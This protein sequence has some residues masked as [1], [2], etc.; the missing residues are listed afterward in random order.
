MSFERPKVVVSRGHALYYSI[1]K[2]RFPDSRAKSRR[3]GPPFDRIL[4]YC[5]RKLGQCK[6]SFMTSG[7]E[8]EKDGMDQRCHDDDERLM[9][10]AT[11]LN[12]TY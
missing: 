10:G 9:N 2:S 8:I 6:K 12:T 3:L 5:R 4:L 11:R 7:S 1:R